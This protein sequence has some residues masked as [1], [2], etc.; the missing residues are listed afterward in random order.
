VR[1]YSF[2]IAATLV[3]L[4][5]FGQG[6]GSIRSMGM[7]ARS[8]GK[9]ATVTYNFSSTPAPYVAVTGAPYSGTQTRQSVQTLP[10]GTHI[11]HAFGPE[12][13]AYRD[14]SGRVRT[15]RTLFPG[16]AA[17]SGKPQLVTVQVDDP[18]GGYRYVLDSQNRVAHRMPLKAG[19][20]GPPT[21]PTPAASY[22]APN[23]ITTT[24]EPLGTQVMF[25]VS[26]TGTKSTTVYPA[27]SRMGN[28]KPV[29][30]TSENWTAPQLG[31]I[32]LSKSTT[33]DGSQNTVS[34][35]DLSMNEP[36]A[37]LFQVPA[38]YKVVDETTGSFTITL[39]VAQ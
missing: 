34:I 19:A 4:S 22:T 21:V 28:D 12:T 17:Q 24:S 35:P 2:L 30:Q 7:S 37:A 6:M 36:A 13:T 9:T 33:A 15:E 26:V 16:M 14:S 39:Q 25:G 18:V 27:G 11:T 31:L 10:D 20:S 3:A 32:V 23:G 5:L 1:N 38:G 29:T 8:D